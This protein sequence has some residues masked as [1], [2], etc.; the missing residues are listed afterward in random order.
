MHTPRLLILASTYPARTGDGTPQFVRDLATA[1]ALSYE[2][3]VLVPSV[4]GGAPREVDG[5]LVVRRFRYFPRRWEDLADGAI[6]ENLRSR[7]SRWVQV[8]PLFLAEVLAIR[9]EIRA[10]KPDVIHV[11]WLVPQGLA[12]LIAAPRVPKL[13]TA[14][15]GDV[16]GLRDWVS[17]RLFKAVLK[18]ASAV[19][20]MNSDMRD[21]LVE[22]G[23]DPATTLVLSMGADVAAIRPLAA[24]AE[25]RAGR[26]LF[27]GRLVE[28]KGVS[29]LLE[30]LRL[31]DD[32]I[33]YDLRIVGD[34]P[35]R[36]QLARESTG[37][38]ATFAGVLG[39]EV[40]A[41]EFGAASIAVFPSVAAASGDQDGLPVALLEAM[42]VGCAVVASDL[43]GLRDAVEDGQ[44]GLLT[45]PGSARELAAALEGLLRDPQLC[46]RLGQAAA[47]RAENFSVEAIGGRYV[48]LLDAVRVR[49][50]GETS[51]LLA[52]S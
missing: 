25:R 45:T 6:L 35:L 13:V 28:K 43:P 27:V 16:Y 29:V 37:L 20:T 31:L 51:P 12:A 21:R 9:R 36:S 22:L 3:T 40:L 44:S 5:A 33:G 50:K 49:E 17:R 34:G 48:A 46:D 47:I 30:A 38:S 1:E 52:T 8:L 7:K 23:A 4:P 32:E 39:R 11:H 42:S 2:T 24:A 26:I 15:G 19:T 14:H 10:V 41:A 18:N